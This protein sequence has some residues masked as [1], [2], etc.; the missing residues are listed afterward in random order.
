M[1]SIKHCNLWKSVLFLLILSL[2]LSALSALSIQ[3]DRSPNPLYNFCARDLLQE[4]ENSI[5]TLVIGTSDAYSG[6]SPLV[7]WKQFGYAGYVWGEPA[8]RI[9]ETHEYLKKI[10]RRQTPKVVFLEVG[11]VYRDPSDGLNLDFMVKAYLADVFP[12]VTYHR[13]LAQFSLARLRAKPGCVAKGYLIRS[14]TQGVSDQTGEY[15]KPDPASG[16]INYFSA[17]ELG[18]CIDLCRSHGSQVVLLSIPSF[19]DW[20]MEKHNGMEALAK[21]YEVPYLDLNLELKQQINWKTDTVD[22]GKHLNDKG[23]EKVS[24]Y[25]G[26]YLTEHFSLPDHRGESAYSSW[27]QDY[28]TYANALKK[29]R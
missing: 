2:I 17:R 4:P 15:M 3:L 11:N 27:N 20:N 21:K 7:W 22:G 1:R 13:T 12:L 25:M 16:P 10:Y 6:V 18:A 28:Q 19:A 29:I 5:D 23:A 9:F 8:Q 24:V 14:G 26:N